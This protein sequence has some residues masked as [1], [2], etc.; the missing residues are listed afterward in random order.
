M[1]DVTPIAVSA[2]GKACANPNVLIELGYAHGTLGESRVLQVWNTAFDGSNP[3]Q[4]AVRHARAPR[5]DRFSSCLSVPIVK[6]CAAF[7][8]ILRSAWQSILVWHWP[9]CLLRFPRRFIGSRILLVIQ[10]CG[11]IA[12]NPSW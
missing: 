6:S 7:E 4:A 5:T 3:R 2:D 11:S 1:G 10:T 9:S 12:P 8:G